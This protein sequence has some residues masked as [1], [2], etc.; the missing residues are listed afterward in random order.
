MNLQYH[1]QYLFNTNICLYILLHLLYCMKYLPLDINQ[2]A[3]NHSVFSIC[4]RLLRICTSIFN[5]SNRG[6]SYQ[7]GN[8]KYCTCLMEKGNVIGFQG[9]YFVCQVC[10]IKLVSDSNQLQLRD[11]GVI[12]YWFG[13]TDLQC[14]GV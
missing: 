9:C 1:N 7:K 12:S 13:Q 8:V 2:S 14:S 5:E 11:T 10:I 4:F 6:S 3:I